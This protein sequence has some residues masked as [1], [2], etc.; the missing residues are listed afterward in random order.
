MK[1]SITKLE[2][3]RSKI[4]AFVFLGILIL[5][6]VILANRFVNY[7]IRMS[8]VKQEHAEQVRATFACM[9]DCTKGRRPFPAE[10]AGRRNRFS[11]H[12]SKR[13]GTYAHTTHV[14]RPADPLAGN[15]YERL[16]T[17]LCQAR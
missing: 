3:I 12:Y 6:L 14:F 5:S 2:T 1:H 4:I 10:T 13:D 16:L 17:N 15:A 8:E 7:S 9:R 11:S